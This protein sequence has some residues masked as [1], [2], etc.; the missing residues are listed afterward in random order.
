MANSGNYGK[1]PFRGDESDEKKEADDDENIFPFFSAR[2]QYDMRAM[3]SA[4]TQVIGNQSSSHDN[5]QHQPVVYNQQDPNPPAPPTQDQGLLRKRHYRGVR[6][7]PWGKWAA[8][9]R[10]PQKAARVWLGTFE[11]AEAA[12]LAYDNAA[13][14]FKGSKAKLNFP[15]RAQLASNTSTTTGPP[16]YYSSNNQ[17]YYSNPQTNPQTIPYFNQYYYNQY[18]HQGG[19]S[20]DALSYSLAG[21]ETGGSMYNHQTLSTTNSSSSGGSSRQQ[22]DEQDY[23]RYLRFGDSS[24]PNSGF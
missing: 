4:L 1:R 7:R 8:E 19:N 12:A 13:L 21:G 22:D 15:E 3:V 5:N 16:N 17:I 24:P 18:L 2:S 11:T 6:Q 20:N 9:I 14:K 23:A 10:D